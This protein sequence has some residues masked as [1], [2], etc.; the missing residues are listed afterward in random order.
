MEKKATETQTKHQ[1]KPIAPVNKR[2]IVYGPLCPMCLESNEPHPTDCL[3]LTQSREFKQRKRQIYQYIL[4]K[5]NIDLLEK[6]H[7]STRLQS[8]S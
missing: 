6:Y 1:Q 4:K 3:W 8:S 2:W 5:Y 7:L